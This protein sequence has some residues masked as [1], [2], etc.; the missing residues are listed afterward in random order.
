MA[1][2][3]VIGYNNQIIGEVDATDAVEAWSNA[4]KKFENVLDVR[5]AELKE[6]SWMEMPYRFHHPITDEW[7]WIPGKKWENDDSE[8]AVIQ[9]TSNFIEDIMGE[10]KPRER[11]GVVEPGNIVVLVAEADQYLYVKRFPNFD[12][13]YREAEKLINKFSDFEE[14]DESGYFVRNKYLSIPTPGA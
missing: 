8:V 1:K 11:L 14:M 5:L 9:L 4:G 12:M 3:S 6:G 2:Y 7:S 10:M 13:A